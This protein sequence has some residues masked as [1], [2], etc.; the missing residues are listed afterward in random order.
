M[1]MKHN[2]ALIVSTAIGLAMNGP[3]FGQAA[4]AADKSTAPSAKT[5]TSSQ[6]EVSAA[7]QKFMR[8]AAAGGATEVELGK[9]TADKATN[10]KVTEFGKRMVTD[11][12]K[13]GDEL[14]SLA[15]QKNVTIPDGP[16]AKGKATIDKLSKLSGAA[17]D[18]AYMKEMVADHQKDVAEFQKAS[19]HCADAD[20]KTWA[21]TTLPTL[22]EHLR[23]AKEASSAVNGGSAAQSSGGAER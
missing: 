14:K 23:M 3:A 7:D 9:L 18:K 20:L 17:F 5:A 8:N 2:I 10:E 19:T 4:P 11:H 6:S 1:Q 12:G 15:S 16:D 22:Q 13:A 21:G